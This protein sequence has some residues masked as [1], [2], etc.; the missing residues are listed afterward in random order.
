MLYAVIRVISKGLLYVLFNWSVQGRE[1]LPSRGGVLLCCNHVHAL[2][3][4]L[5]G[6]GLGRAVSF[7]AKAEL[8]RWR[9]IGWLVRHLGAFPVDRGR[10]DRGAV[11]AALGVLAAGGIV[12]LFPE[13]RRS[14]TGQLGKAESGAG[15]LALKTDARVV[16]AAIAGRYGFRS[17]LVVLLGPPVDVADVS[18]HAS[19][20]ERRRAAS[21]VIMTRIAELREEGER[22]LHGDKVLRGGD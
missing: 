4:F 13:G 7:M 12:G 20:A 22:R 14:R 1:H 8:F 6:C 21:E 15:M 9:P 19:Q 10:P 3:P 5:L 11:R 18:P 16:P 17:R 2:D